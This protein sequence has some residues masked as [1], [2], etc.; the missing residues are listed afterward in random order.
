MMITGKPILTTKRLTI[1]LCLLY[2][3]LLVPVADAAEKSEE[4]KEAPGLREYTVQIERDETRFKNNPENIEILKIISKETLPVSTYAQGCITEQEALLAKANDSIKMLGSAVLEEVISDS[5][6]KLEQQKKDIEE[7]LSQCRLLSVR[8]KELLEQ[9]QRAEQS[10]LK[11]RLFARTQ[12]LLD[13]SQGILLQPS[14]LY[15]E[16]VQILGTLKNLPINIE[17]FYLALIYGIIG[18][19]TGALWSLYKLRTPE[20]HSSELAK[21]SPALSTVWNSIIRVSPGLLLF[22]LISLSF[23]FSPVEMP[24]V[25]DLALTLL[26]FT[27]SY[28]ILR[29]MLRPR[30]NLHGFS[31]LLPNASRKLFYWGR[32]LLLT[33]L[34]GALFQSVIFDNEPP[35]NLVGLIRITLGTF[36]GLA[37][38][39]VLWLLRNHV[40][41]VK[42]LRLHWLSIGIILVAIG[43]LWIGYNKFSAFLFRGM[44]GT[45]FILL[46]GWLLIRIPV[47]IFDSMDEG[48]SSW[49]KHLRRR[50]DLENGQIIPGLIWLRLVHTLVIGS[51]IIIALLRLWGMS[52]QSFNLMVSRLI[53][54]YEIGDFTLAPLSIL[55]GFLILS[56][57]ILFTQFIKRSLSQ[58]WFKRTNLSQGAREATVTIVG[59]TGVAMAVFFGLSAVGVNFSNLAI[60]AGALSVGIGF[61]LQ[62]IVSNFISGLILLFERPIRRGDWIRAGNSEGYVK[63]ISIRS[64]VIKTFD[65]SDIIVPNSELISNQVTNMM[66]DDQ[67]GRV[68]IPVRVAYGTNTE[69]VMDVLQG[70]AEIHPGIL[71]EQGKL[72]IQVVLRR[73]GEFAMEF[74][75][76]CHIKDVE[77]VLLITSELNLAIDKAFRKAGIEMPLPQRVVYLKKEAADE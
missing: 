30:S 1:F 6:K 20:N 66:L 22:G 62:N 49:Q 72:K 9:T 2:C 54:G 55:S 15:Q 43:A 19:L 50:M 12:S 45:L 28:T 61:G 16:S 74:E 35:S 60:V 70:V 68:V 71:R 5:R 57:G 8:A 75:L 14:S 17:N 3:L 46:I 39:R 27:V 51:I 4:N 38:M 48:T 7:K 26:T 67:V 37:L 32:L 10:V 59:Y 73:F 31:P 44:F 36:I 33:T 76:R 58:N 77:S 40:P 42:R 47:E 18:M 29:A 53:N 11:E 41:G 21:T 23:A 34:L 69:K 25:N 52:E 56:F 65:R 13:Y 24:A 63:K 64:T